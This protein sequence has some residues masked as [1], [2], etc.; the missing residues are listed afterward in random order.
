MPRG[1]YK[2]L[3]LAQKIEVIKEVEKGVKKKNVTKIT[4]YLTKA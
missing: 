1:E 2:T 3:T 4:S